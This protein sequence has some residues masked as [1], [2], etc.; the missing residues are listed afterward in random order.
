MVGQQE[1]RSRM[2]IY[3]F[4]M[5]RLMVSSACGCNLCSCSFSVRPDQFPSFVSS[6]TL[7]LHLRHLRVFMVIS[8]LSSLSITSSSDFSC[9]LLFLLH[10]PSY[11]QFSPPAM[12]N[13][14]ISA[15][16]PLQSHSFL[17]SFLLSPLFFL[18]TFPIQSPLSSYSAIPLLPYP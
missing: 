12:L 18:T 17:I 14:L 2:I 7:L 15:S 13:F 9:V 4:G 16:L 3:T 8:P 10:P 6:L 5:R 1:E 11:L